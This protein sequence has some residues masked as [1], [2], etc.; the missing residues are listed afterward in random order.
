MGQHGNRPSRIHTGPLTRTPLTRDLSLNEPSSP[1][2]QIGLPKREQ[3][4]DRSKKE[5]RPDPE[6]GR[7]QP[8]H[9]C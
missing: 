5:G 4:G 7:I 6:I 2:M 8:G 9:R 3:L 1:E